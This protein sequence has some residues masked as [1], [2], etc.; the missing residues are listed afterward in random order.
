MTQ[1]YC[2][3][4][5]IL[6]LPWHTW[7][8]SNQI[9]NARLF[10][11]PQLPEML[12]TVLSVLADDKSP[13]SWLRRCWSEFASRL[14]STCSFKKRPARNTFPNGSSWLC[15]VQCIRARRMDNQR[16]IPQIL[17][18]ESWHCSDKIRASL[19]LH[20]VAGAIQ[21]CKFE[22]KNLCCTMLLSTQATSWVVAS[23]LWQLHT[24]TCFSL[25]LLF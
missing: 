14:Q 12:F 4:S 25:F 7:H 24:C 2:T 3:V 17:P 1:S 23:V 5:S 10:C 6:E 20:G 16:V 11:R 21:T 15:V 19:A 9:Y 22:S 18:L 13:S 8:Q